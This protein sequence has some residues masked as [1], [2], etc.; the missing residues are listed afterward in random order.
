ME[1][2]RFALS[3]GRKVFFGLGWPLL[4]FMSLVFLKSGVVPGNTS[5][6]FYFLVSTVG[7]YGLLTTVLYFILFVP[8]A[9]IFPTY[10]F[11]R[12]WSAFLIL[13]ATS[14]ILIDGMVFGE[15]RFHI[16]SLVMKIASTQG[17]AEVFSGSLSAYFVTAG[18]TLFLFFVLWIRGEWLWRTMQKRFS[19]PVNNWYLALIVLCLGLS[20]LM[21]TK[22]HTAFYGN[23]VTLA[24]LFPMNY[25]EMF[26]PKIHTSSTMTGAELHYPK[27]ET[28]CKPKS[29]SHL[30]YVVVDGLGTQDISEGTTSF[31][32]HL[33]MHGVNFSTHLSGGGST[34]DN[35]FRLIYGIP[36]SYRPEAGEPV[37]I[38]ELRKAGYNF[39]VFSP[40]RVPGLVDINTWPEWKLAHHDRDPM[41]PYFLY[42]E[43]GHEPAADMDAKVREIFTDLQ[44]E[45]FLSGSTIVITGTRPSEWDTVPMTLI[46][47]D[48]EPGNVEH[49]TTHYDV[50]PSIMKRVLH[51]T[52]HFA[53]GKDLM[54]SPTRD[55][56]IFGNENLFRIVDFTHHNIIE[57]DWRGRVIS[58]DTSRGDLVLKASKEISRY[59]RR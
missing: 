26:F 54:E 59:Y 8:F 27:K 1:R 2:R 32:K 38:S 31:L 43:I 19:N 29:P 41:I 9:A 28:K 15:Y 14:L 5:S 50:T 42:F 49:R 10:Y 56:E 34:E 39:G 37:L 44:A 51:C 11:V 23:E 57:S 7:Y 22:A 45:K 20:H 24:S 16:N 6:L 30:I 46:G 33:E 17:P 55:W 36:A 48:R 13:L 25:Q 21:W 58:G 35:L 52:G 40:H 3:W 53:Y 12:L 18:V 47:P 4:C